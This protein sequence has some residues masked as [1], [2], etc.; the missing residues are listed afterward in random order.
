M[1]RTFTADLRRILNLRV[2]QM[3]RVLKQSS[4]DVLNDAQENA[5]VVTGFLK[6]SVVSELNGTKIAEGK[7]KDGQADA[8][9]VLSIAQLEPGDVLRFG[10]TAEYAQ[11][12]EYGFTDEDKL[13]R[14]Y[15]QVGQHFVGR[16]AARW[17]EIVAANVAKVK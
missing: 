11:R 12:I 13:G 15:N 4:Q 2:D 14:A 7:G 3:T 16:A 9:I 8:A 10:F 5:P 6:N 1:A 17:Q